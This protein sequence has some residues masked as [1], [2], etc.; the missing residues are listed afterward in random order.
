MMLKTME[1][2]REWV[3]SKINIGKE[4][5]YLTLDEVLATKLSEK[6][7]LNLTNNALIAHGKKD[8]EMPAKVGVHPFKEV[9]Y[10]AMPAYVPSEL[11]CGMK[12]VECYPNNPSKFNLPQTT[13]LI[14][15][16]DILS[17]CPIAIMDGT[18]IT[19]MRTP[20]VTVLAAGA[21]H[22][23]AETFGMF[24]CGVQG[25]EHCKFIVHTLKN[26]K[27][28]YVNDINPETMDNLIKE[29][30]PKIDVEIIKCE[31]PEEVAKKCEVLSSATIIIQ[32]TLSAVKYDWVSKGQT[33]LPCDLNTFWDPVIPQKADK[34][35]VDS[36]DEHE[37]FASMGYF[38]DGLPE[39]TCETGEVLAGLKA[40]RESKDELI[41]CSNIGMSVC[42]VVVAREVLDRALE[43]NIGRKLPL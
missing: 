1:K 32:E 22:P 31:D 26:L 35:I 30:Q 38:P 13:G 21:L 15:L 8:Y 6:D 20:A 9:F 41:V 25:I 19:A 5:W 23:D 14:V 2:D 43:N 29:V 39:I 7:I 4:L 33:I 10:H 37:M 16:N 3:S 24:G 11:A 42:D 18:W 17:G 12:W 36:I 40:G 34:Y 27:K 28:I